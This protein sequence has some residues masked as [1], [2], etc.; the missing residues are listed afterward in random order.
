MWGG[1]GWCVVTGWDGVARSHSSPACSELFAA[2][3]PL[4]PSRPSAPPPRWRQ[5]INLV[6][7]RVVKVIGKVENTERFLRIALFQVGLWGGRRCCGFIGGMRGG[8][9]VGRWCCAVCRPC[10]LS[11]SRSHQQWGRHHPPTP[12]FL[13][14]LQGIPKRSKKLPAGPDAKIVQVGATGVLC[15]GACC[16]S[17]AL[18]SGSPAAR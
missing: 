16:L 18:P 9:L 1:R 11:G 13:C 10:S 14:C 6:T 8:A 7:N 15:A 2:P 4:R 5:V 3:Q 12:T 17:V